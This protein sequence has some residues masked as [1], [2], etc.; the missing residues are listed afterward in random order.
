MNMLILLLYEWLYIGVSLPTLLLWAVK[1][2]FSSNKAF[3]TYLHVVLVD[4][5]PPYKDLL[6]KLDQILII[7]QVTKPLFDVPKHFTFPRS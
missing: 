7:M 5:I 1:Y 6:E 4:L 3:C 2:K